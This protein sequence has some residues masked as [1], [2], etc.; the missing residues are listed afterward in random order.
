MS[1]GPGCCLKYRVIDFA[2]WMIGF[3]LIEFLDHDARADA[4]EPIWF[5]NDSQSFLR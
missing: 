1:F 5:T 2:Q 3:G 4:N